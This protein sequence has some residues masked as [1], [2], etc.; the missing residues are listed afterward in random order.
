[1][2]R[3]CKNNP[4]SFCYICGN[5]V[6]TNKKKKINDLEKNTHRDYFGVQLGDHDKPFAP[7]VCCKTCEENLR[8]WRN[9]KRKSMLFAIPDYYFRMI[10]LK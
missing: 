6:L 2:N 7:H 1:M 10:I 9:D 4:D 5:V 3:M 8:D